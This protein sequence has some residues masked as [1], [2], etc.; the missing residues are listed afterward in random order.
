MFNLAGYSFSSSFWALLELIC[1]VRLYAMK[2]EPPVVLW[3]PSRLQTLSP[4][5]RELDIELQLSMLYDQDKL[6]Q[7]F[8]AIVLCKLKN[9]WGFPS[10]VWLKSVSCID[11]CIL[12]LYHVCAICDT[13]RFMLFPLILLQ[14][15]QY[16]LWA[17]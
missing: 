17:E 2:D 13:D 4:L 7:R 15:C 6:T 14:V 16:S 8:K 9:W 11:Q 5:W 10:L 3:K 1:A 12:V